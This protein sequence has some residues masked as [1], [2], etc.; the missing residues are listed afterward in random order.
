MGGFGDLFLF[1]IN[2]A[3]LALK[4]LKVETESLFVGLIMIVVQHY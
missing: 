1:E 3:Y 4:V 2:S